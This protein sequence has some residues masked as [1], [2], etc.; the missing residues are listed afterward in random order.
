[1]IIGSSRIAIVGSSTLTGLILTISCAILTSTAGAVTLNESIKLLPNDGAAGDTFGFSVGIDN[2]VV[3]VG[4]K[5]DDI[6]GVVSGSAY[7]FDANTGT[8]LDKFV[9]ADGAFNDNFGFSVAI[10]GG[11]VAI[12]SGLNS[13]TASGAGAAYLYDVNTGLQTQKLL[14]LDGES[15]DFLGRSVAIN[16][17]LTLAGALLEDANGADAGAAYLFDTA[18]GA[19]IHKL[20]PTD[21]V[22]GDLL[23]N[24]SGL[25]GNVA[26]VGAHFNDANGIHKSGA[27]YLFD[28]ATGLQTAKLTA[29]DGGAFDFFG[30]SVAI[31]GNVAIVSA[32]LHAANGVDSGAA[33]LFDVTTGNQIAKL[34][35]NDGSPDDIFGESVAIQGG[36][37][38]VGAMGDDRNGGM[39]AGSAYLF[40][41]AT[42]VQL[43]K[44]QASDGAINS[45]FGAAVGI[46]GNIAIVGS[47]GD[48]DLG[49]SSG[50]AYLFEVPVLGDFD[51]DRDVDLVD[52]TVWQSSFGLGA[53]ADTDSDGDT[54]GNDFLLWQQRFAGSPAPGNV[55]VPEPNG[56]VLF[57]WGAIGAIQFTKQRAKRIA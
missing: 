49:T 50:A 9:P 8:Q 47:A 16:G 45:K 37:A 5:R 54:D 7:L 27:A 15:S 31:D 35:P 34:L 18:T 14:A 19:Q 44:L 30:D 4:S 46:S 56:I 57:L 2:G 1:M 38:I 48:D 32:P 3:I 13:E 41:V 21:G 36:V 6:A 33:Y 51:G 24:S 17:G 11:V 55:A 53:G 29:S 12:G 22:A 20:L 52:L 25:S 40:D 23:G 39:Y 10:D 26:I 43:A 28:T 42:G